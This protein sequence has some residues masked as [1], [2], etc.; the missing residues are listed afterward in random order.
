MTGCVVG[1]VGVASEAETEAECDIM[2]VYRIC[3]SS[4]KKNLEP[5][6]TQNRGRKRDFGE[7]VFMPVFQPPWSCMRTSNSEV[8]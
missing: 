3:V 8:G 7:S 5:F 1:A 2:P 6:G 4:Q